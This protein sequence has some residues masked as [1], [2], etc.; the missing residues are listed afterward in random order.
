MTDFPDAPAMLA[1][2]AAGIDLRPGAAWKVYYTHPA[3]REDALAAAEEQARRDVAEATGV[4]ARDVT[5]V[6]FAAAALA[7]VTHWHRRH[8]D[9]MLPTFPE[10]DYNAL[11]AWSTADE[12]DDE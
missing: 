8:V 1:L 12:G 7:A 4:H 9:P 2:E 5:V 6:R 10:T 11:V 3:L